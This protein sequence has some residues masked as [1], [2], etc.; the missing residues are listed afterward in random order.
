MISSSLS[1]VG[2]NMLQAAMVAAT[3]PIAA[4][5]VS[6]RTSTAKSLL[7]T[8]GPAK[9][10]CSM[11]LAPPERPRYQIHQN[12]DGSAD[13]P[14]VR[15]HLKALGHVVQRVVAERQVLGRHHLVVGL[16]GEQ[17]MED[18]RV[19]RV[20]TLVRPEAA[21]DR[22]AA[23]RE[24][25]DGVKQL[26]ANELVVVPKTAGIENAVLILG[27]AADG[28]GIVHGRPKRIARLAKNFGI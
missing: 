28:D 7:F 1:L 9:R 15:S 27:A 5:W 20:T 14:Q 23:E 10:N 12:C 25:A 6:R 13:R 4:I 3:A 19:E 2:P 18:Q 8:K 11:L 17:P 24:I 21:V 16:A 22:Q 26:V